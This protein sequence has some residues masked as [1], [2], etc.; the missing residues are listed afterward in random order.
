MLSI[1]QLHLII[2]FT[3]KSCDAS[4]TSFLFLT[5][6]ATCSRVLPQNRLKLKPAP[7][8]GNGETY[9]FDN[10]TITVNVS[11]CDNAAT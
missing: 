4:N 8:A 5:H 10:D 2:S 9:L 7:N 1:S 6:P 3:R 11:K